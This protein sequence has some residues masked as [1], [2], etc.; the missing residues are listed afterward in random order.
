MSEYEP[1][2]VSDV[3]KKY[4]EAAEAV[5][6]ATV[7]LLD[8]AATAEIKEMVE[9]VAK[10]RVAQM[11]VGLSAAAN[12][13][14]GKKI[15]ENAVLLNTQLQGDKL[16]VA[17]ATRHDEDKPLFIMTIMDDKNL[18]GWC[19]LTPDEAL[20]FINE[21]TKSYIEHIGYPGQVH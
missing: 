6:K 21:F 10:T 18:L 17:F 9:S 20:S 4:E 3:H 2:A 15:D 13:W 5:A 14:V 12:T 1:R 7:M 11:I 16:S 19:E 8:D